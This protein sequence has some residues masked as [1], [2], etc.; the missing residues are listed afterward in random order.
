[1]QIQRNVNST[2]HQFTDYFKGFEKVEA[3]QKIFKEKTEEVL[4]NLKVEFSGMRGYMGV[5]DLDGHIIMSAHYLQEGDLTDIYLD[6][7]HELAHVKQFM[8]GKKLF[9]SNYDYVERPTEIEAYCIAVEEARRLGF[10]DERICEYLK[11]EWMNEE[12][13]KKLTSLVHVN[14]SMPSKEKKS[15]KRTV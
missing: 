9:D 4:R 7:I 8:E 15:R 11:T 2:T 1:V 12:D 3:V 10:N 6:I 5:S 14:Y 13:L